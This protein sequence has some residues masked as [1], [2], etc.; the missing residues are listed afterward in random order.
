MRAPANAWRAADIFKV[1]SHAR[2]NSLSS[3]EE[4][5]HLDA[6]GENLN[7]GLH[8]ARA[9]KRIGSESYVSELRYENNRPRAIRVHYGKRRTRRDTDRMADNLERCS[10]HASGRATS[11]CL[12]RFACCVVPLVPCHGRNDVRRRASPA[13]DR[14]ELCGG[15][16]RCGQRSGLDQ[17]L[18]QLGLAG[19][20]R[21]VAGW[22]RDCQT[23]RLHSAAANGFIVAGNHRRSEP[24]SVGA[25]GCAAQGCPNDPTHPE[26]EDCP[27]ENVQ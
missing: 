5:L 27:A 2:V 14:S 12:A 10:I 11:L 22:D 23:S 9:L 17:P 21:V 6:R 4:R 13:I 16:R 26:T 15:E 20:H 18:R 24:G 7:A 8:P 19:Y 3:Y 1:C 25:N